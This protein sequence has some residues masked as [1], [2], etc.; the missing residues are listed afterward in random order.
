M[1]FKTT[2]AIVAAAGLLSLSSALA[3][4]NTPPPGTPPAGRRAQGFG[5]DA[6]LAAMERALGETNKLSEAQKA[7]V[8]AVYE[9][10]GKKLQELMAQRDSAPQDEL[11]TKRRAITEET[12]K[13]L[14]EI[15]TPEQFKSFEAMPQGRG[16]RGPRPGSQGGNPPT[17][18][19]QK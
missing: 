8:K 11:R 17:G 14:K 7:K 12:N 15:L 2:L 16:P 9:E 18:G 13:K 1:K 6:R 5:A 19:G 4:T 3:Q 10:Q